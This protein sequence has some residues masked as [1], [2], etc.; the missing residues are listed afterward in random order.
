MPKTLPNTKP[1]PAETNANAATLLAIVA[2][3]NPEIAVI[4]KAILDAIDEYA[5]PAKAVEDAIAAGKDATAKA[6]GTREALIKRMVAL[7][8]K[9]GWNNADNIRAGGEA[10]VAAYNERRVNNPM[11]P[12]TLSQLRVELC[13]AMHPSARPYVAD[14]FEDA[15]VCWREEVEAAAEAKA[16]IDAAKLAKVA[17]ADM[18]EPAE[19]PLLK[20]FAKSYH[21]VAGNK[22]ILQAHI[23]ADDAKNTAITSH[24]E[25]A[26]PHMLAETR[27]GVVRRDPKVAARTLAKLVETIE[28][29]YAEFPAAS[30]ATMANFARNLNAKALEDAKVMAQAKAEIAAKRNAAPAAPRKARN[31]IDE[32]VNDAAEKS[33]ADDIIG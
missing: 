6:E 1:T 15:K 20:T 21:M 17:K 8:N 30:L 13:R 33:A 18:P 25:A 16:A 4:T 19:R 12:A 23:D 29:I 5:E 14:A 28:A 24:E 9:A 22:G 26:D 11:K 7:A 3:P 32:V 27:N 31:A 10:A 2:K